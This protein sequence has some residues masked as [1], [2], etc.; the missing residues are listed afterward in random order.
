MQMLVQ[1]DFRLAYEWGI[2]GGRDGNSGAK[3][4]RRKT[5]CHAP[6]FWYSYFPFSPGQVPV[7][8]GKRSSF[9]SC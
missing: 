1:L 9:A 2:S 3:F 7:E 8:S 5:S 4:I 6:L